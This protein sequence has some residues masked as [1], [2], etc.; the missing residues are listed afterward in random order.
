VSSVTSDFR[1]CEPQR[2]SL[3][4]RAADS[5]HLAWSSNRKELGLRCLQH[6]FD[7]EAR[8][9]EGRIAGYTR[10]FAYTA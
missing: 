3:S 6:R 10:S 9:R 5:S 2:K 4:V 8:S 1:N 7:F